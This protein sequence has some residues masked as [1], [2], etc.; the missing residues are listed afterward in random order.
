VLGGGG[1]T[2]GIRLP[3]HD[4]PRRLARLLG[5]LAASSANISG[6]PDATSAERVADIFRAEELAL[7]ID[8][9]PVRGGVPSTVVDCS[10]ATDR[11]RIL[12]EGAISAQQIDNALR[13]V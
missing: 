11:P 5:P 9:G 8:D 3:D 7:I 12:R 2:L 13:Q 1:P 10:S 6:E 4:V